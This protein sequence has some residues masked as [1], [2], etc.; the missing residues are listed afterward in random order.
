MHSITLAAVISLTLVLNLTNS[1]VPV[2]LL[3]QPSENPRLLIW[4]LAEIAYE[5]DYFFTVE[6]TWLDHEPHNIFE[7]QRVQRTGRAKGV[8]EELRL[9]R[10]GLAGDSQS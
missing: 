7:I 10:T 4:V 9:N 2:R 1:H 8:E 5:Y 3:E 6:G